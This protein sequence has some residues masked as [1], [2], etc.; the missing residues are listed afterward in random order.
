MEGSDVLG[1][2]YI[3]SN[4]SSLG[5]TEEEIIGTIKEEVLNLLADEYKFREILIGKCKY[6]LEDKIYRALAI[7]Q[8]AVLLDFKEAL[9]L[10]SKVRLGIEL[11]LVQADKNKL[12]KLIVNIKDSSIEN[13]IGRKLSEKEI[14]YER[15]NIVR[16]L[17]I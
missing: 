8:H 15:A 2:I 3:I 10:I 1:N 16:K 12:N 5:V 14:K 17:L 9:D 7:L 11:S 4:K 6:E 13:T